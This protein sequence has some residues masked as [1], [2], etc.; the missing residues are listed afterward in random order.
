M[1]D[2]KRTNNLIWSLNTVF[3]MLIKAFK[4]FY[5]FHLCFPYTE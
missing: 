1:C 4:D 5:H 2:A 3:K